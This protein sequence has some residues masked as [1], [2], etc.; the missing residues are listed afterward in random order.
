MTRMLS[1]GPLALA[2]SITLW[3]VSPAAATGPADAVR[4]GTLT[5]TGTATLEIS[6]DCVDLTMEVSAEA[7]APGLA[8]RAVRTK[9][10]AVL[11]ALAKVG[12]AGTDVRLSHVMLN[13][14][15]DQNTGAALHVRAYSA[16]IVVT[17][18]TSKLDKIGE[19][20]DVGASAGV[21]RMWSSFRR[22]NLP[23]L[24]T[25]VRD[26]AVAAARAKAKQLADDVGTKLG[27]VV[28]VAEA[29]GGSGWYGSQVSNTVEVR[30]N[31]TASVDGALQPLTLEV[32]LGYELASTP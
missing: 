23:E 8:V 18:T 5:V 2:S 17:A 3:S 26:M 28:S 7:A 32:T 15:Y 13:P 29:P 31:G 19:M 27:R 24:K 25:R 20:M 22:T 12:V 16:A 11:G 6:P 30:S 1:L 4:P 9:E 21:V 14:V 10:A